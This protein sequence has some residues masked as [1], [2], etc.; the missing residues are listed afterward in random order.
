MATV[1]GQTDAWALR[2]RAL[3]LP[4]L[5]LETAG[6]QLQ[7]TTA[8]SSTARVGSGALLQC[9]FDIGGPVALNSLQ[10]TWYF[11]EEKVAWYDQGSRKALHKASLP[12][13]K[14]LQSGDASLSLAA[15]TVPDGGLYRCVVGY[16]T[17]QHKG[18]TTLHLLAAPMISIPRKPAVADAETSL[19]CHMWGFFPKDVDV[20]WMR[21][22]QVLKGSTLSSPQRNPDGT[23]N[24]T[25]TYT[26]TPTLSDAGS[27]FSCHIRHKALEQPIQ[28]D[29]SLDILAGDRTGAVV[30]AVLGILLGAGAAAAAAIYFWRKRKKAWHPHPLDLGEVSHLQALVS[31]HPWTLRA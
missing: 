17:Q 25:L 9:R 8:P 4:L 14:E 19:L 29:V 5:F 21:D 31:G 12:S 24:L 27:I 13:E 16:G 11:W 2:L 18:E 15:V 1:A 26:F 28:E 23:F 30:G 10:V 22:G 20:V 6:S 3:L 7:V